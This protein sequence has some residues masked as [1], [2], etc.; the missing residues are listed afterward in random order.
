MVRQVL[1]RDVNSPAI[2]TKLVDCTE[3]FDEMC[4]VLGAE[5]VRKLLIVELP[6]DLRQF[7]A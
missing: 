6:G 2:G 3:H 7:S 4:G 1:R 5:F